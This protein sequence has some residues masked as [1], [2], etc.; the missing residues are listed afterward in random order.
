MKKTLLLLVAAATTFTATAQSLYYPDSKN[1]DMARHTTRREVLRQEIILP[2]IDGCKVFKADLHSHTI[3]SDGSVTPEYRVR[4]AWADGL[5][6]LAITEHVEYRP[7]ERSMLNF[8]KGY[9]PEGTQATNNNIIGKAADEK[10]ILADLNLSNNIATKAAE[11]YGITIIPGIE[12]T[13]TPETIGHYNALFIENA[14]TIYAADAAASIR[15]ARKQGAIIMHNHP[16]WRRKNLEMT[17]FEKQVYA[18]GL[19]DGVETMNGSEFYPSAIRRAIDKTLF[20]AANTD[21]HGTTSM[22]Y[23]NQGHLRNMTLIIAKD[24]RLET[25]KKAL[26]ARRTLAYSFGTIAGDEKLIKEFFL[27]SISFET[28]KTDKNGKRTMRMTNNTSLDYTLNFGGNPVQL[29][30]FTSRNVT[31][32]KDKELI[33]TVENMWI[34]TEEKHPQFKLKL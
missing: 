5:D 3:F 25:I 6:I 19:I 27:A 7:T 4:E 2:T 26:K 30:A 11:S 28:F 12:I 21:I 24:A 22:D 31:V 18:E 9:L 20:M 23:S 32:A 14:N 13:R 10:G 1:K 16:G 17:D 33:F 15:N 29:R 34:P 8:L